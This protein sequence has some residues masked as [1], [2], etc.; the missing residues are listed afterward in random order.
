MADVRFCF[1]R[2]SKMNV[3]FSSTVD[4]KKSTENE[5]E[6]DKVRSNTKI[7]NEYLFEKE[8]E[9][10]NRK[11]KQLM[12]TEENLCFGEFLKPLIVVLELKSE[13]WISLKDHL[14][15]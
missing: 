1:S 4:Q 7:L 12:L 2:G 13:L 10:K 8:N 6:I 15:Q 11:T 14:S 3:S 5:K 9:R